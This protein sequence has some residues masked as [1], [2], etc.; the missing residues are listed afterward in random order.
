[1]DYYCS[2]SQLVK[3]LKENQRYAAAHS[4]QQWLKNKNSKKQ[5]N[6]HKSKRGRKHK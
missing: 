5:T 3:W 2:L 6:N 4:S 1:M